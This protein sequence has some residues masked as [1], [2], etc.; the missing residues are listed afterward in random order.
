MPREPSPE[1]ATQK[2]Q[3]IVDTAQT[4]LTVDLVAELADPL[5]RYMLESD[6]DEEWRN[7]PPIEAL[8]RAAA[9]LEAD[10]REVPVPILEAL[11]KAAEAGRPVGLA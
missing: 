10:G 8:A 7:S 3:D 9:L 1:Q 2:A 6:A 4:M 11:K 5:A